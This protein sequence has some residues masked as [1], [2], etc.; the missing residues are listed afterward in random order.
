[1]VRNRLYKW[2]Q[3]AAG[4]KLKVMDNGLYGDMSVGA[5]E[6]FPVGV[7]TAGESEPEQPAPVPASAQ[8]FNAVAKALIDPVGTASE[9]L[10]PENF[11][12]NNIPFEWAV[13]GACIVF[14]I[15]AGSW[16]EKK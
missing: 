1:M 9:I 8:A 13:V 7:E 10:T 5:A 11:S 4:D 14:A 16:L 2:F 12:K 15:W 6:L 3:N